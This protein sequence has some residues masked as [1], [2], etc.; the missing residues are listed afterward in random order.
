MHAPTGT[1]LAYTISNCQ[2]QSTPFSSY[3]L[4][5]RRSFIVKGDLR[6][7][8]G[9]P[10]VVSLEFVPFFRSSIGRFYHQLL[11]RAEMVRKAHLA[12]SWFTLLFLLWFFIF[13]DQQ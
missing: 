11:F 4:N 9:A 3:L 8:A 13:H 10:G 2:V 7:L 1:V 12:S 6:D 5:Q